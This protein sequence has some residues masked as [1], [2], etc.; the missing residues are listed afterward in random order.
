MDVLLHH[1]DGRPLGLDPLQRLELVE[2]VRW[3]VRRDE[4]GEEAEP[5]RSVLTHIA[6]EAAGA[7]HSRMGVLVDGGATFSVQ[8]N[9][10]IS[11]GDITTSG[12]S[13]IGGSARKKLTSGLKV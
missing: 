7:E 8:A 9:V 11:G 13:A 12:T 4:D 3:K 5:G 1:D 2:E 10:S 6:V